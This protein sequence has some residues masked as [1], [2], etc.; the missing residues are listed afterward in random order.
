MVPR[1]EVGLGMIAETESEPAADVDAEIRA[2]PLAEDVR[3]RYGDWIANVPPRVADGDEPRA[4]RR[5]LH[6]A[7]V[8]AHATDDER[9]DLRIARAKSADGV[10]RAL[11]HVV[12]GR[13]RHRVARDGRE[14]R[15]WDFLAADWGVAVLR[16]DP[17]MLVDVKRHADHEVAAIAEVVVQF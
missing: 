7:V 3:D 6:H 14:A 15:H 1:L 11:M 2:R 8:D 5:Q 17:E 13:H 9:T 10:E 16:L 4:G 12:P